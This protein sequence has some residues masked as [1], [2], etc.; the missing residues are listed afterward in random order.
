MKGIVFDGDELRVV[1][2]LEVRDPGPNEVAVRIVNSGVCHS[3]VSVING[4]IPFPT[5]V[6]LGHEGAGVVEA[7]GSA[8]TNVATGDHVVLS[9]LGQCG[10]CPS[11]DAGR[12]TMCRS[13]FGAR[14]TPFTLDGVPHHNFAN[15]SSFS[16]HVVVRANQAIKIP[17]EV[18]LPA[19][20]LIG[21]GVLTGSGAV[22][23]RAKVAPGESVGVIGVGGIG[24]NVIQAAAISGANPIIAVDTNPDKEEL[25]RTFGATHFVNAA[26]VDTNA[27]IREVRP[28]G[29][30]HVFECVGAKALIEAALGYL[31]WGGNLVVLG[32]PP[33][34]STMEF[35]TVA[36]YLDVSIMGC[37]YGSSRPQTDVARI[38]DLYLAGRFKLDELVTQVYPMDEIH[39]VLDDMHHGRLARGVLEVCPG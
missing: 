10:A 8:V 24:L 4:T 5:P 35:M 20:S 37:R 14:D 22:F 13:T 25:A 11:C 27:A 7:V 9:T 2:G 23:N 18:P 21:C 26:E 32:V 29:L 30:D 16:E 3:D 6:V 12:P 15:I 34:G 38:C 19:A 39:S 36:T 17:D 33:L 1:E 28:F 31:D